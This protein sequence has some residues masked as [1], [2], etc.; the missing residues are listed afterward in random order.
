VGIG[1]RAIK[2]KD[3]AGNKQQSRGVVIKQ[4]CV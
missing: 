3:Y 4:Y 1:F 2:N